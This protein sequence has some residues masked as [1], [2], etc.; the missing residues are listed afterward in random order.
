MKHQQ[1]NVQATYYG[2]YH[3]KSNIKINTEN[4]VQPCKIPSNTCS[5]IGSTSFFINDSKEIRITSSTV[6]I[7]NLNSLTTSGYPHIF[8]NT[9]KHLKLKRSQ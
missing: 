2:L 1:Y 4:K 7:I 5:N 6:I 8:E 9:T 3:Y